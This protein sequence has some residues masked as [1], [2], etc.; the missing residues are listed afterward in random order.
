MAQNKQNCVI[1]LYNFRE[2]LQLSWLHDK[3][4]KRV[5]KQRF[6]SEL[7][8]YLKNCP[9]RLVLFFLTRVLN[10]KIYNLE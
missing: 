10:H 4:N 3:T 5:G 9:Q 8:V 2:N 6:L 7:L 1:G